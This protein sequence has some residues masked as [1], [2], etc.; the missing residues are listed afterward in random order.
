VVQHIKMLTLLAQ[1]E[2]EVVEMGLSMAVD[3]IFLLLDLLALQTLAAVVGLEVMLEDL[4]LL[5]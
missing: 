4:V 1:E 5:S 3:L 2:Q